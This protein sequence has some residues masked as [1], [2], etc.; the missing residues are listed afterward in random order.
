MSSVIGAGWIPQ[1]A[2]TITEFINTPDLL[3]LD[4]KPIVLTA[5][6]GWPSTDNG[7]A[8]AEK[9]NFGASGVDSYA[10]AFDSSTNEYAQW[11]FAIPA[12][13]DGGKFTARFYWEADSS[14][15]DNVIWGVQLR[16]YQDADTIQQAFGTAKTVTDTNT[17]QNKINISEKI[18]DIEA[19]GTPLGNN[20]TQV[21]VYRNSESISDTLNHDAFLLSVQLEYGVI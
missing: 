17:G 10:L 16:T 8:S 7:C 4:L 11:S 1:N 14:D 21:R 13:W 19:A 15:T 2:G 5:G 20:F 6:G 9:I 3:N 18:V 12:N